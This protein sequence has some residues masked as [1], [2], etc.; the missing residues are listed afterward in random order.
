MLD[1]LAQL[2][3]ELYV[4]PSLAA[5]HGALHSPEQ[6]ETLYL[7]SEERRRLTFEALAVHA[8]GA[9]FCAFGHTHLLGIFAYRDG[10]ELAYEGDEIALRADTLYLFNPGS[11]GQPRTAERRATFMVLDVARHT[12]AVRRVDYDAEAAFAKTRRAGL[13]PSSVIRFAPFRTVLRS[14]RRS[15][16]RWR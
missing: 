4:P 6:R 12:I 7:N 15:V 10:R 1:F 9:R 14:V 11:V 3:S 8:S 5:V 13:L 16:A 2:P